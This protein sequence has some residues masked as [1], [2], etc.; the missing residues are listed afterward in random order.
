[1][2]FSF[3]KTFPPFCVLR[4]ALC[5]LHFAFCILHFAFCILIFSVLHSA[6]KK[7]ES[8][9]SCFL[10]G[11]VCCA[12]GHNPCKII[13]GKLNLI[14]YLARAENHRRK[15]LYGK[16]GRGDELLFHTDG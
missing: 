9:D 6:F 7:Q 4:F 5:V 16:V 8:S 1:M 2:N 15:I 12:D 11:Y 3:P 14:S 13:K 10:Y